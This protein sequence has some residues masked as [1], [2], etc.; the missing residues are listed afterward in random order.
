ML[1]EKS[2]SRMAGV[3]SR[4]SAVIG[5]AAA[6]CPLSFVVTEGLR[7]KERQAMLY[8]AGKTQTLN[9]QHLSGRA[10]DVCVLIDGKADWTFNNYRIVAAAVKAAA[11]QMN[12]AVEWGGDWLTF[13]DG[14]H[15]Q[16]S[17]RS[18]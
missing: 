13:K 4:L 17:T 8:Q 2:L 9:S 16:L 10:V 15:F 6:I 7:S 12:I 3:D 14:P 5:A 1:S 11:L 18:K